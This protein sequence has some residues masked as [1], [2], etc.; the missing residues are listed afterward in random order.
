MAVQETFQVPKDAIE[1]Y[2]E[3]GATVVRGA[4]RHWVPRLLAAHDRMQT[5]LEA[6]ANKAP[7]G[8]MFG[9]IENPD[10]YPP[11]TMSA[12]DGHFGIRNAV[13]ADKDFHDWMLYSPAADIIGQVIGATRL[14]FWWDQ[15]FC[16]TADAPPEAATPWHTDSG[17]FSFVGDMLPS[18]WMAGTD[19]GWNNAPLIT[20]SGS[21][22]DKRWFR[23]VFG[24]DDVKELPENYFERSEIMK[25]VDDPKT[26]IRVWTVEAG[27][28][29]VIH[30]YTYHASLPP[31]EKAG[32]RI[33]LTSRW[34]GD[35]IRWNLRSMTFT[36][37]DD[38]RFAH[39]EQGKPAPEDG[40]PIVW[41][42]PT[43]RAA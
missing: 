27:D 34:L 30:P 2:R 41:R 36:Y 35:D 16:K 26:T 3:E 42:S 24:K 33:G 23:P 6:V 37:P 18:F 28:C 39:I 14:Q 32:R 15:S 40:F 9:K 20:V 5:R 19:V 11:L 4:F 17:S 21:H 29:L 38:K 43:R 22:R 1:Q 12:A 31:G 8:P 13:F 25:A 10:G 7:H